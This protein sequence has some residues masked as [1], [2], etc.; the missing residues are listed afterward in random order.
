MA[1]A[2]IV[3]VANKPHRPW[4]RPLLVALAI[5][6]CALYAAGASYFSTHFTPGTTV[7]GVDASLMTTDQL[8]SELDTRVASYEQHITSP[9]GYD[10][11][12]AGSNIKLTCNAKQVAEEAMSRCEP[13]LWLP[14][15]FTNEN[16][17]IDAGISFDGEWLSQVFDISINRFNEQATPPTNADVTWSD[18]DQAYVSVPQQVGTALDASAVAQASMTACR[19]LREEVV[20]D[21]TA[22]LQP[23]FSEGDEQVTATIDQLNKAVAKDLKV[24][25]GDETVA[26][27]TPEMKRGWL[28]VDDS[29]KVDVRGGEILSWVRGNEAIADAGNTS[30]DECVWELDAMATASNVAIAVR[31][32]KGGPVEVA[33]I[34]IEQKP[35]VTP[36]AKQLGRHV[37]VNLTYQFARFYDESGKVIWDSYLVS[38]G[39]DYE[40]G[41]MHETPT[42]TFYLENK[43]TNQTLVGADLDG[44]KKPDYESFVN[45]WMPF[46]NNDVGFH[47]ATWRSSFG[48]DIRTYW[49]SH[50]CINL[51]YDKAVELW[52]IIQVGDKVVV[53]T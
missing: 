12:L 22:L 4:L 19:E 8:A 9:G 31:D 10:G 15:V 42:G 51:P 20:L 46:L 48:G 24:V 45:Y 44:D 28:S 25:A 7:D 47:D 16:M 18:E 34:L 52:N 41:I 17:L 49:G 35:P 53:H 32:A 36:G 50:G 37:D 5:A 29:L 21:D 26:T 3:E 6:I 1:P 33:R 23:Q 43:A 14:R 40:K 39:W 30:D 13:I 11:R 27:I 2:R 38:G